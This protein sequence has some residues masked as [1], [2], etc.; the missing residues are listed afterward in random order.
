[1]DYLVKL[2]TFRKLLLPQCNIKR[3]LAGFTLLTLSQSGLAYNFTPTDMEFMASSEICKEALA[4]KTPNLDLAR[5]Y[6]A[7]AQ[8]SGWGRLIWQVGGW[9][10]C[11]GAIKLNR[12]KRLPSGKAKD[13]MLEQ[14]VSNTTYSYSRIA[15]TNTWAADM[16][17]TLAMAYEEMGEV[18]QAIEVLQEIEKYHPD[19]PAIKTAYGLIYYAQNE[20][21]QA[22][23]EFTAANEFSKGENAE[24]V[25]FLGL[26]A[27]KSGNMALAEECATKA[28]A[29]GYPLPGL[30]RLLSEAPISEAP[31]QH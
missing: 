16:A 12:A 10:Y 3:L 9:H 22:L 14:V 25:Y 20:Y 24:I 4:D 6:K 26:T 17:F 18:D 11:G 1:M 30:K 27:Y 8:R 29:L 5:I 2:H 21:A 19:N 23:K 13:A 15:K 31:T 28:E 7:K